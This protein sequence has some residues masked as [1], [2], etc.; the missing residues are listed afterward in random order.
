[1]KGAYERCGILF[2]LLG[3]P[4]SLVLSRFELRKPLSELL[5]LGLCGLDVRSPCLP[6]VLEL[7]PDLRRE[8]CVLDALP[9]LLLDSRFVCLDVFTD[10]GHASL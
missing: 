7:L 5:E 6:L 3:V 10:V 2:E 8:L 4:F 1:M 9:L